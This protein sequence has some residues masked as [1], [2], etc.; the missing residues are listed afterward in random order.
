MRRRLIILSLGVS[1]IAAVGLAV[2]FAM[3]TRN[4]LHG[5]F[6]GVS[7][8]GIGVAIVGWALSLRGGEVTEE[9]HHLGDPT[10]NEEI[11]EPVEP[12]RTTPSR[13]TFLGM[14]A[15]AG[16]AL[17][18]ALLVPFRSLA[19]GSGPRLFHTNWSAGARLV[20]MDGNPI[21]AGDLDVGSVA[22]VFPQGFAG[23]GTSQALL[24]RV[25]PAV[26]TPNGG[27]ADGAPDGHLVYSKI[28]THAGCPV[29]LY[30]SRDQLLLCPCHQSTFD[31]LDGAKPI[32]GPAPRPLP[33]L[34]I[35]IDAGGWLV[36]TSDFAEPVG[37]GF[38][39]RNRR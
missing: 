3:S 7:L 10:G 5:A 27:N 4:E 35:A 23:D 29:G 6:L 16:A 19:P 37:P 20:D 33:Q 36:A 39:N 9:R 30:E 8:G 22:T 32:F 21:A 12:S 26:L 31:V 15:A 38:W 17:I 1:T 14:L 24:I 34:P 25:D 2:S 28:C 13:R 11:A 18:A